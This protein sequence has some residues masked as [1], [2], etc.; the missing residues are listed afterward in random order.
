MPFFYLCPSSFLIIMASTPYPLSPPL[1]L[2]SPVFLPRNF[3]LHVA[4]FPLP[5]PRQS[6]SAY[7]LS[8]M[9]SCCHSPL[10]PLAIT[11]RSFVP[12]HFQL[13][14]VFTALWRDRPILFSSLSIFCQKRWRKITQASPCIRSSQP[15][16][17]P[18][19]TSLTFRKV[20]I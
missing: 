19:T 12:F 20:I 5:R 11:T 18:G 2:S 13:H 4:S 10:C 16:F 1:I 15:I 7:P 9:S 17:E 14:T 8:E 6:K 3:L